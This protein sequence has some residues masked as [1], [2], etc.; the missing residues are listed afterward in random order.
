MSKENIRAKIKNPDIQLLYDGLRK[1][2]LFFYQKTTNF[3]CFLPQPV[4][5][6]KYQ[7]EKTNKL[8][9]RIKDMEGTVNEMS[10]NLMG[11]KDSQRV[12]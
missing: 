1:L 9:K 8:D 10:R 4:K 12:S 6:L 2:L 5:M 11:V 7:N 3:I